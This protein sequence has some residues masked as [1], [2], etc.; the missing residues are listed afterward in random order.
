MLSESLKERALVAGYLTAVTIATLGWLSALWWLVAEVAEL[1][2]SQKIGST[3]LTCMP[4]S[5]SFPR[6]QSLFAR[7][8]PSRLSTF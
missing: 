4:R 8:P 1:L 2:I 7:R 3:A 6:V 5:Q